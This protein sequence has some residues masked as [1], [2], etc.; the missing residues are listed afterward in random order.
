M[1]MYPCPGTSCKFKQ[2]R[3]YG[4]ITKTNEIWHTNQGSRQNLPRFSN[5]IKPIQDRLVHSVCLKQKCDFVL[6]LVSK[7]KWIKTFFHVGFCH[8]MSFS[9]PISSL[10]PL[11]SKNVLVLAFISH[12][13]VS[14]PCDWRVCVLCLVL[15][16][17]YRLR[18]TRLQIEERTEREI[19][20]G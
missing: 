15:F 17:V 14:P 16:L 3:H 13:S 18:E 2:E 7:S 12:L 11:I 6:D 9:Y 10:F 19:K 5:D 20:V 8:N 4:L 1:I